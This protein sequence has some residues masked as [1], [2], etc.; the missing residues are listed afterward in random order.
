MFFI[1]TIDSVIRKIKSAGYL[2]DLTGSCI[3]Q[4][5]KL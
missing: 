5:F 3:H 4:K 2:Y 1:C